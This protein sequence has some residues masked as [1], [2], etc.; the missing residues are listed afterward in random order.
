MKHI[1]K[2]NHI[3]ESSINDE[4]KNKIIGTKA[5][6]ELC[7]E[8]AKSVEKFTNSIDKISG[9]IGF[10]IGD[11]DHSISLTSS[12]KDALHESIFI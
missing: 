9:E 7:I 8:F 6:T 11:T 1:K 12:I 3:N 5:Y 10:D 4:I 2:F